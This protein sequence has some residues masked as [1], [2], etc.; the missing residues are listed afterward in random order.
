VLVESSYIEEMIGLT[1]EAAPS[2]HKHWLTE[3]FPRS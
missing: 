1:C 3:K 2:F